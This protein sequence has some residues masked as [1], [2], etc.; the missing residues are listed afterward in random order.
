MSS[1]LER[2]VRRFIN[3]YGV[4]GGGKYQTAETIEECYETLD[5][6]KE[7][8]DIQFFTKKVNEYLHIVKMEDVRTKRD[9]LLSMSDW[10]QMNDVKLEDDAAWKVY[11][12][13]LRDLPS[14]VDIEKPVYPQKPGEVSQ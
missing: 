2:A 4:E 6:Y 3:Q 7:K 14:S 13:A 10:T 12:Q 9:E 5:I 11:R 8:P 1:Y